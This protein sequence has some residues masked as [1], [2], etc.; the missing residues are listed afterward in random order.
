MDKSWKQYV[1][2]RVTEIRE[3]VPPTYWAHCAG[4]NIPAD[5][6]SRGLA[7]CEL[8]DSQLWW[9]GP[10]WLENSD[11]GDG[12]SEATMPEECERE[13]KVDRGEAMVC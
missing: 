10:D 3:L 7:P 8:S 4:Q 9:K 13:L 1:Q 11:L 6:P 12:N 5:L 2:N